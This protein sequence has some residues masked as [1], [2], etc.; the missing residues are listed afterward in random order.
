MGRLATITRRS[1]LIGSAAIA[2]GIA[3]GIYKVKQTP[4]NPLAANLPDGAASF[5]PWVVI[6]RDKVTL[7][8]PHADKGQ[9]V[10]SAQ[11]ALIADELDM[12]WGNFDISF[13]EPNAAYWNTAMADESVPF[14]ATDEGTV[15]E[16]VRDV[17]GGIMKLIG[18]QG[19]GGSTSMPDSFDK[20]RHA[21]AVARETLKLTAAQ[22][23]GTPVSELKTDNGAVI[24][25]DGTSLPYTELAADAVDVTPVT[26][27]ELRDPSEWRLIG[28][29]MPRLDI[30]GKSTGTQTYGIDLSVDG[31][32]HATVKVNPRQ[33]GT[34]NSYDA[35]A[36]KTM[37]GV[38]DVVE[39]T[40]G[41]AV[42]ASNTW[43]AI[44]AA[45]TIE[46]D[47]GDAPYPAEQEDHWKAVDASFTEEHL[48]KQWRNDG[49]I[50]TAV[51]DSAV[52]QA[53]YR[54]PYVAHQPLE[55]LNA[56]VTVTD[57]NIEVWTGH[58]VPRMLQQILAA[59]TGHEPDQVIFH[60]QFMGG[61][62]GHRLEF[63]HVKQTVE[64]ANQMR[65]T[66]VK[67]T[68]SREEDFAHDFPRH[69]G[70][71]KAEGIVKDGK[72]VG[73]DLR[74]ATVSPS[75]SQMGRAGIPVP[76]PDADPMQERI[77]LMQ[78][79]HSRTVLE[80]VAEMS[81]WGGETAANTAKG[82]AFVE[83]FGVPTAA[84]VEVENTDNGIRVTRAWIAAEVG[85]VVDPVNFENLVQGGVVW[86]LGHAINCEITYAD[87]MAQQ[88]NYHAHE[89]MRI[90]NCP[91]VEVKG[92]ENGSKV[93]GIGE[94][95]VPV[96]APALANAIFAATG[97]R[98]REMPF[99]RHINFV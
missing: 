85:T 7:I 26:D 33:G 59:V 2:G 14:M 12:E 65:G 29:A 28:K 13:G 47:W 58:Q 34:M 96:T 44:Q 94:P 64:I 19:T 32:V 48:D 51:A 71:A 10:A 4:D 38:I 46:F 97:Q 15:A 99:N 89:A 88:S 49:D 17:M 5:N 90:Y 70:A 6:D 72:V 23:T 57:D 92:L 76:G 8:V 74:I 77:R 91:T 60:N 68:Y 87:G 53:E 50:I 42:I 1:F 30:T 11:A 24:L 22:K 95:P 86:G 81:D 66:P 63:E 25:P 31:M 54:S 78:H 98:I 52:I 35:T 73:M 37:T 84:V 61:S 18:L 36:A 69:I 83:S 62:F 79:E 75:E 27:V 9:G 16:T 3:F 45:N 55:P 43:Y 20:L 67:M 39:I 82:V 21:G 93:R 80:T 56:I 41:V 40:N